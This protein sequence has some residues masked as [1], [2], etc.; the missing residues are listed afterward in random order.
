MVI[1]LSLQA[2]VKEADTEVT[3]SQEDEKPHW[4]T[5]GQENVLLRE[6]QELGAGAAALTQEA[7]K[8]VQ[9]AFRRFVDRQLGV[10]LVPIAGHY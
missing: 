10:L 8:D 2:S 9:D 4:V 5:A 1:G 6:I 7:D 3:R